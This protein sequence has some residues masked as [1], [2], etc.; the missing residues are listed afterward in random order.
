MIFSFI[1]FYF[2]N[3]IRIERMATIVDPI[4]YPF[5]VAGDLIAAASVLALD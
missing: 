5:E 4:K 2:I 1:G 3:Q